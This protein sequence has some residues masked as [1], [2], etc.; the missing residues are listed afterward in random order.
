MEISPVCPNTPQAALLAQRG[1][2]YDFTPA[3][4]TLLAA[5]CIIGEGLQGARRQEASNP[6][7]ALR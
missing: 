2:S 3:A 6:E 1:G 7:H 5:M 4:G